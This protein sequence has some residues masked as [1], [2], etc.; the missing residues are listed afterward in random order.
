MARAMTFSWKG[1]SFTN[2]ISPSLSTN[3]PPTTTTVRVF[4]FLS[5]VAVSCG[6]L[7]WTFFLL[8]LTP[9]LS[10]CHDMSFSELELARC[11]A[12]Q[13]FSTWH[14]YY[15]N[16]YCSNWSTDITW[17]TNGRG[18]GW[19]GYIATSIYKINFFLSSMS[20]LWM[21]M[22]NK[23]AI[24]KLPVLIKVTK[25]ITSFGNYKR[26]PP[27]AAESQRVWRAV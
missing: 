20:I 3:Q 21:K 27:L 23:W 18:D 24:R 11:V 25:T 2:S 1:F 19:A 22:F 15:A 7:G 26:V 10:K 6:W 14:C 12:S 4:A 9:T 5:R 13:L 8:F 16:K 17:W